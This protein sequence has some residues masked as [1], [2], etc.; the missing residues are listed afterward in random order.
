MPEQA[1]RGYPAPPRQPSPAS[2]A[3]GP[4][5]ASSVQPPGA[6][7]SAPPT[8]QPRDTATVTGRHAEIEHL[9]ETLARAVAGGVVVVIRATLES[10]R[11]IPADPAQPPPR[12][13]YL[14]APVRGGHLRR[15]PKRRPGLR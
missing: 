4:A 12:S 7:I 3:P 8:G 2:A 13:F 10:A 5:L 6:C 14:A 11:A 15:P 9:L 1:R